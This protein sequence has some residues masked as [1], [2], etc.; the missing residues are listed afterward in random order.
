MGPEM[1]AAPGVM[2]GLER[3]AASGIG[4]VFEGVNCEVVI[5]EVMAPETVVIEMGAN[6]IASEM[7]A[8]QLVATV[9]MPA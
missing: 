3:V 7:M 1:V 8:P 4:G 5:V 9:M 6:W 2:E